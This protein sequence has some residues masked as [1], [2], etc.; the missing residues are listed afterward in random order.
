CEHKCIYCD[1]YS[2][3]PARQSRSGVPTGSAESYAVLID[4]FLRALEREIELRAQDER[5]RVSYET[6]FFGG[7]TPSLLTPSDIEKILNLLARHFTLEEN[8]EI[9]LETNPGTVDRDKLRAF[10]AAGINR[11][12]I[13][14]Q[15][16]HED[17]LRFL[18]RIHSAQQAKD[19][20]REASSAGFEN[21]SLDLIFSLPSQT[22]ERWQSNLQQAVE[23]EPK[24]LSTYSLIVE[25]NT[26]LQRMVQTK[27]VTPLSPEA[28]ADLYEYTIDFL[29][30]RGYAQYEVSN[31]A[32]PGFKSRHNS[33]YW[34]HQ[35]YLGFGPSAH[36]FWNARRWWS[37]ANVVEYATRLER[38]IVPEAGEEELS[39]EQLRDEEIFLGLRSE[40][41]DVA[42]FC[43]RYRTNLLEEYKQTIDR[44]VHAQLAKVDQNHF[45][46]TSKGYL[47]CDEICFSFLS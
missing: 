20:V 7:G 30:A 31:F 6:I 9:T 21:V 13:G 26:P 41:I 42:G 12:S 38:S 4:R 19:C 32:R 37:V 33:N 39:L 11:L 47:L 24:H 43:K 23:L 29:N 17:D 46:L 35:N 10:R 18:S 16:F 14:I 45:R 2:V 44:L 25:P 8:A 22:L 3:A 15:S 34:N 27:Q 36:S 1:F 40:G 5:F 28:D